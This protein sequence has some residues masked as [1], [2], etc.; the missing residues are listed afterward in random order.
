MLDNFPAVVIGTD[1]LNPRLSRGFLEYAQSCDFIAD[2]ARPRP[3][4]DNPKVEGDVPYVRERFFKGGQFN[5]LA[6]LRQQAKQWRLEVA[7]QHVTELRGVC[8]W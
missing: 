8:R 7:G 1:S 4:K 2:P 5:G 3:P 6:D